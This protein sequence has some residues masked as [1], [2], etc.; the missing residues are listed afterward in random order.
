MALEGSNSR[1]VWFGPATTHYPAELEGDRLLN[2]R[3]Q[4]LSLP[5]RLITRRLNIMTPE[6]RYNGRT[7]HEPSQ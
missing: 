5:L 4:I 6:T 3:G 7:L 2:H 1:V